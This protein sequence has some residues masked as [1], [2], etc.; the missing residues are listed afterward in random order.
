[1]H[2]GASLVLVSDDYLTT[3]L[4]WLSPATKRN[5]KGFLCDSSAFFASLRQRICAH[6]TAE[7]PCFSKYKQ[8]TK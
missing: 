1:M 3:D 2:L 4:E 7:L 8:I 6:F 5:R